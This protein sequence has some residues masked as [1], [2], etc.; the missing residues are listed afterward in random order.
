[1][2]VA[3]A[4]RSLGLNADVYVFGG[5]AEGRLTVLSDVDVLVCVRGL[6]EVDSWRLRK[7]ILAEAMD[8]HGLPWDYPVEVHV[9][10]GEEAEQY[11]KHSRKVVEL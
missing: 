1:M 9:V 6:G 5:A 4:V 11:F 10:S 3:S 2:A 8:R 7:L